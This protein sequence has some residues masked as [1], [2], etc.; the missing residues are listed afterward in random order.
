MKE[1]DS[2]RA[3]RRSQGRT[4]TTLIITAMIIDT[5]IC[6]ALGVAMSKAGSG[7][8]VAISLRGLVA[9]RRVSVQH[10]AQ[11]R[12]TLEEILAGS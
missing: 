11:G 10:R 5:G 2:K 12:L 9:W 6:A 7:I 1:S 3:L 8:L 4:V